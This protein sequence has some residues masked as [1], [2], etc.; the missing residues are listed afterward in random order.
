MMTRQ[1]LD[2]RIDNIEALKRELDA[3]ECEKNKMFF[4]FHVL[5]SKYLFIFAPNLMIYGL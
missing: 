5:F 4:E 3:W 2:R 1:C